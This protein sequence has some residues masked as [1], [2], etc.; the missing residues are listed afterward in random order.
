MS[1]LQD[2]LHWLLPLVVPVLMAVLNKVLKHYKEYKGAM[3]HVAFAIDVLDVVRP[4]LSTKPA[5]KM[6]VDVYVGDADG[7]KRQPIV[8]TTVDK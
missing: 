3:K 8:S 2:N 1:Y 4:L 7:K 6:L 5:K